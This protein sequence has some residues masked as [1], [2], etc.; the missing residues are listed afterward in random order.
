[1][2]ASELE[3]IGTVVAS[4][5]GPNS[6]RVEVVL[7]DDARQARA[8]VSRGQF[9]CI[10]TRTGLVVGT[11]T[12]IRAAN[13]YYEN[14]Q[15]IREFERS[16][17]DVNESFPTNTWEHHV[18]GLQ[19]LGEF[20]WARQKRAKTGLPTDWTAATSS[21]IDRV[22]FPPSPGDKAYLVP[23]PLLEKFLGLDLDDGVHLGTVRDQGLPAKFSL[24]RLFN[25]HVAVLAVSGAGKSYL[26]A[27]CVE[28]LLSRPPE[29]GRPAVVV[30]DVHGEYTGMAERP[31][32]NEPYASKIRVVDAL[33][34]QFAVPFIPPHDFLKYEHHMSP[35]QVRELSKV[36]GELRKT[37]RE[38]GF[39]LGDV[40]DAVA[41]NEEVPQK[42]RETLNGWLHSL[43]AT[44]FFGRGESPSVPGL[45]KPGHAVVFDLS[46]VL[47]L[48][49]R[50]MIVAYF[51]T[52]LFQ[53]RKEGVVCPFVVILEEAHQF[54][55]EGA[56][57]SRAISRGIVET[58]AR[59][60]RK[61]FAQL[62]LVSQRPVKL[63]VTALSQCNTHLIL[64]V[65][66]PYDLDHIKASS[67]HL[68]RETLDL[69]STLPVGECLVVGNATNYPVFVKVRERETVDASVDLTLE[70]A[71][72]TFERG[73][74]PGMF[75]V[76]ASATPGPDA[77]GTTPPRTVAPK[78][79]ASD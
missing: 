34:A 15:T 52:R 37:H 35:A 49:N 27:V 59:E 41:G 1:M 79:A 36:V 7:L 67:E 21:K 24:H 29:L 44:G 47:S 48:R 9:C 77:P 70:E 40:M 69:I 20:P 78:E 6:R 68:T 46:R 18:A 12:D 14:P 72:R 31:D 51:M 76:P 64:R 23:P 22:G 43:K 8:K 61:F 42:T 55:P 26:T 75:P 33:F 45:L 38:G 4:S 66:N 13:A 3:A 50:Q 32:L 30:F 60:G 19:L 71:A 28:E 2:N 57:A 54:V 17:T 56:S 63:S 25:R 53:L 73:A 10:P 11:V 74:Q 65:V 5:D 62:C 16:G 39:D 58:V